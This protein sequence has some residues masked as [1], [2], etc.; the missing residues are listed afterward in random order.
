MATGFHSEP[1]HR[2]PDSKTS[3][4][5]P[6]VEAPGRDIDDGEAVLSAYRDRIFYRLGIVAVILLLPFVINAFLKERFWIALTALALVVVFVVDVISIR[7]GLKPPVP[8]AILIV[9]VGLAIG[10]T[11]ARQ[12]IIGALW[13][14]PAVMLFQF[15]ASRWAA[16]V[17]NG[18]LV[19]MVTIL[20]YQHLGPSIT[21]RLFATLIL[22]MIFTNI[23][24]GIVLRLQE[25]LRMLGITDALTGAYNRRHM[26]REV[27]EAVERHKRYGT[28]A[29]LLLVDIDHFKRINDEAGHGVGDRVLKEIAGLM[30]RSLR[31]LDLVFRIGGEEFLVLL[32]DIKQ[33]GALEV[34]E[35]LRRE[36]AEAALVPGR[37]VSI[38][39]GVGE[40][41]AGEDLDQWMRRIDR[42]LYAAKDA[43]RDRVVIAEAPSPNAL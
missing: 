16:N 11:I 43:G 9:P 36:V 31:K 12:G 14:F 24:L 34:A 42:A 19:I 23:F 35:K 3:P 28:H 22:T 20:S 27:G 10:I 32:P 39:V 2:H 15:V 38:S 6:V 1:F 18:L 41:A 37:Q 26:D 33:A 13:A 21:V 4:P 29:S 30:Q 7:R 8:P 17:I 25:R 5:A 40:I